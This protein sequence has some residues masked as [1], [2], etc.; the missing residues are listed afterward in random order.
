MGVRIGRL[1]VV[2][3]NRK[4]LRKRIPS[5]SVQNMES[6]SGKKGEID[7]GALRQVVDARHRSQLAP[8]NPASWSHLNYFDLKVCISEGFNAADAC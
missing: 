7:V 2:H 3:P 6:M 4:L 8:A 5:V 1:L